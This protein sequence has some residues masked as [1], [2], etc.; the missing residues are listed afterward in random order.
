M[1][2]TFGWFRKIGLAEGISFL[3]LLF[4]A[5]PLKHFAGMPLAV[6]VVGGLHGVLFVAFIIL[7]RETKS[8][9]KKDMKWLAT[10]VLVS[11]LPFGTI[12]MDK[13]WKKEEAEINNT[14]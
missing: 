3:V 8:E 10:A 12:F 9:Y 2:K 7:A 6:T 11:L 4:I 14:N 1:K 5:M 13:Q